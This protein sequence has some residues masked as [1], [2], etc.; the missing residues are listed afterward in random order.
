M[1]R[2]GSQVRESLQEAGYKVAHQNSEYALLEDVDTGRLELW[3]QR[4]DFAGYVVEINGL[5]YEL[6]LT[7]RDLRNALLPEDFMQ[8]VEATAEKEAN[9][10]QD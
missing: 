9:N 5:G 7:Y 10:E 8:A 4:D 1:K 6:V 3:A 2:R